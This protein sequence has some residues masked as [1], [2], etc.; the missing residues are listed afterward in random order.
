MGVSQ[1]SSQIR[2]F[3]NKPGAYAKFKDLLDAQGALEAWYAYESAG[4][5]DALR[6]WAAEN[7]FE[8]VEEGR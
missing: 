6:A 1:H 2:G 8:P 4:V 5:H 7:D 3:F